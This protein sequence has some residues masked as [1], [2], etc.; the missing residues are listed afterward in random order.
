MKVATS[1]PED[2]FMAAEAMVEARGCTRSFLYTEALRFYLKAQDP[3]EITA[4]LNQVHA[5]QA[6]VGDSRAARRKANRSALKA[7]DW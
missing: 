3:D 4:R 7:S 2:V 1:L 5:G 6:G